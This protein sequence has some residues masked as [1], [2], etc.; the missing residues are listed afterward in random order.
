MLFNN[1]IQVIIMASSYKER[2]QKNRNHLS[3]LPY[4]RQNILQAHGNFNNSLSNALSSKNNL[5]S[6]PSLSDLNIFNFNCTFD[7][8]I[9]PDRNLHNIVQHDCRYFSP[10]SFDLHKNTYIQN[11]CNPKLSESPIE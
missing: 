8:D 3:L 11:T 9:N 6:L 5:D 1:D 10:H 4:Y 7:N 2:C